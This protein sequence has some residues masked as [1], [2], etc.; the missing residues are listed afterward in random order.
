MKKKELIVDKSNQPD[1]EGNH[2]LWLYSKT[3]RGECWRR[4]FKGT[5]KECFNKKR[6]LLES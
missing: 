2:I 6:E 5:R 4:I 3:E 1:K